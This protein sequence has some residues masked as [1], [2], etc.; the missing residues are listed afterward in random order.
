M[1]SQ[2]SIFAENKKGRLQNITSLRCQ[3]DADLPH[4]V[5]V[6]HHNRLA[7]ITIEGEIQVIY[8]DILSSREI[9]RRLSAPTSSS[10]STPSTSA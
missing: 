2:V 6:K 8:I 7:R 3:A 4:I 9:N 5:R 10:S 1:L